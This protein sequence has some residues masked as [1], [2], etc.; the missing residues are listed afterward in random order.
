MLDFRPILFV[1]TY[2]FKYNY[3][4]EITIQLSNLLKYYFKNLNISDISIFIPTRKCSK[5]SS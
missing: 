2:I 5:S 3:Y 1:Y 4:T